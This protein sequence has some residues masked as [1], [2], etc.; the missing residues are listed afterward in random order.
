M[1][2]LPSVLVVTSELVGPFKNGGI[3]T[4][5]TGLVETLA[6]MGCPT[7]VLYTGAIWHVEIDM[8]PWIESWRRIGVEVVPLTLGDMKRLAGPVRDQGL[9]SA[10]LVYEFLRGRHFDIVHFNDTLG[11]GMLALAAKHLGA[12][13]AG[14]RMIVGLHSPTRWI[15]RLNRQLVDNMVYAAFDWGE[16]ISVRAADLLWC[17]SEYLVDWI[18]KDGWTLPAEVICQQYVMPTA[19]LFDPAPEKFAA[20]DTL[21]SPRGVERVPEVVFFGRLEERKGLRGFCAA[22][23]RLEDRLVERRTRITFMGKPVRQ[24][25]E[26]SADWLKR[27]GAGWR[28]PWR[29]ESG[30][31]QREAL[32]YLKGRDCLAVMPSPYDNSPC[33][34]YE[35]IQNG[36]PFL[37][38]AT[39]GIPELVDPEDAPRVLFADTA[40]GLADVLARALEEGANTVRPRIPPAETRRQ[41]Q[42]LHGVG[43]LPPTPSREGRGDDLAELLPLPSRE[44]VGGRGAA[45]AS[46]LAV[47]VEHEGGDAAAAVAAIRPQLG[48]RVAGVVLL[49]RRPVSGEVPPDAAIVDA[50]RERRVDQAL[51]AA[52]QGIDAPWVL[53]LAEGVSVIAD[54]LPALDRAL[55]APDVADGLL[56]AGQTVDGR[57]VP[58]FGGAGFGFFEGFAFTGGA[59]LR[60]ATVVKVLAAHGILNGAPFAGLIDLCAASGSLLWPFPEPLFALSSS[61]L[62]APVTLDGARVAVFDPADPSERA[63][64]ASVGFA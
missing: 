42:A 60:R 5:T 53:C 8:A 52:L 45:G 6:G 24:G 20:A 41:W 62:P 14:T 3:G 27:R 9:G 55:A 7:T 34:V 16:R 17:P 46:A 30:F 48:D 23:D 47:L 35:A 1:S 21:P 44:G 18:R 29:I 57:A 15:A 22:L 54:T 43:P 33:T 10:W 28:F 32:A 58:P 51:E 12:A 59:V 49:V 37:A 56:P 13:F 64:I 61:G 19:S 4:A 63:L 50:G 2:G 39:G 11:E 31:G 25:D 26:S 38:S 40:D 36:I